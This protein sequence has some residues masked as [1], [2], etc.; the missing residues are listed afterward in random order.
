[1][2]QPKPKKHLLARPHTWWRSLF[3]V[4]ILALV[5]ATAPISTTPAAA[6]GL[7]GCKWDK[8]M[9]NSLRVTYTKGIGKSG[10]YRKALNQARANINDKTRL[11]IRGSSIKRPLMAY[12][13]YYGKNGWV[14][15]ARTWCLNGKVLKAQVKVNKS[16]TKHKPTS[17]IKVVWLHE[18]SHVAGL[19]HVSSVRRVMHSSMANWHAGIRSLT[20]DEIAAYKRLY[21]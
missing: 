21:K 15:I 13:G 3:V 19:N 14:G 8:S 9:Q 12:A 11:T 18:L 17:Y 20:S 5:M 16:Y 1:M 2:R 4:P 6:Y 7:S 10:K